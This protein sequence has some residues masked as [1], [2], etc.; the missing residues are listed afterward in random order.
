MN[1]KC[2]KWLLYILNDWFL[3]E[4]LKVSD[5]K[6]SQTSLTRSAGV[7][8]HFFSTGKKNLLQVLLILLI[9]TAKV[10]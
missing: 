6:P 4:Q 8:V 3:C 2:T 1:A 5:C 10:E 7:R 9:T